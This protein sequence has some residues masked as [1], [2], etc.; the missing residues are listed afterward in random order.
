MPRT[1][2][3]QYFTTPIYYVNGK[4]H[5]GHAYSTV[6]TDLL[7]R[8]GKVRGRNVRFLTGTDEHGQKVERKAKEEGLSPKAFVD[9]LIPDFVNAWAALGCEYDDFLRTTDARHEAFV[10]MLW[11]RCLDKGDIYLGAY[12]GWYSTADE[13]YYTEKDVENGRAKESGNVVEWVKEPTYFFRLS[14]YAEPLLRYYEEHP[15][16]ITP[17][18][19]FNEVKSFVKEGLRDLSISRNTVRW[20]I[21]VPNDPE[22]TIYVWFD[23]LSNYLSA[24]CNGADL[25]TPLRNTFWPPEGE[26]THV[27][28][29]EITR[30]H[31][32]YWPAFLMSAGLPLPTRI[33]AH[34]WM[35]VNGEKMSKTAGNFLAP[36]PIVDAIGQDPLR[37][38]LMKEIAL[39]QD[40]DFSHKN[41]L[42]RYHGDLGNG[43]G[44]LLNRMVASIVQKSFDGLVPPQG[45]ISALET[46]VIET[47]KRAS[48]NARTHFDGLAPHKA[49]EA[50]WELVLAANKYIDQAEPWKLAKSESAADKA[51][52]GT[53]A[54]TVLESLRWISVMLWPVMPQKSDAIRS[55]LGILPLMT[56]VNLDLWPSVW[57]GLAAGTKTAPGAPLFPRFDEEGE[58]Q[59]MARMGV[60]L[61]PKTDT[62]PEPKAQKPKKEAVTESAP[63]TEAPKGDVAK[64]DV[65]KPALPEGLIGIDDL[66]K[67]EMKLGLVKAAERVPKSDKLL[68]LKI[69]IGE[70]EPRTILAGIGQHYTPEAL[71]GRRLAVVANL[72]PRPMMGRV[73]QGMVLAVSDESGLSVLSPDKDITPGVR[74]K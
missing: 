16:F 37:Y 26:V 51:R 61:P 58:R 71:I 70:P 24:L 50:I 55:Q 12:E 54:Y 28:G 14:S 59:L 38:Y 64:T 74:L 30:F 66:M 49:L 39:G 7:V 34:G 43:L 36:E 42:A 41:L 40:G 35:T 60:T 45:E 6:A 57:G 21:P 22:F 73:S 33:L 5:I 15:Q 18:G 44:N 2:R 46:T 32:V 29:K 25:D 19:R 11:Q 13:A 31:A 67:V 56:T 27:M 8:Y 48:E 3:P 63:K 17:E 52:L 62:K 68:E 9:R 4:P 23:A 20:G 69:D 10:A 72:P 47:A 65:A 1:V 53:V